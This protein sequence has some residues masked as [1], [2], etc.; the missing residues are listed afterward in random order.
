MVL[1]AATTCLI[2]CSCLSTR[3]YI[4]PSPH[5]LS[6]VAFAGAGVPRDVQPSSIVLSRVAPGATESRRCDC[7]LFLLRQKDACDGDPAC[8][9]NIRFS[10]RPELDSPSDHVLSPVPTLHERARG[11]LLGKDCAWSLSV[12]F[13]PSV[14]RS[15]RQVHRS[16]SGGNGSDP[17]F[18]TVGTARGNIVAR[19]QRPFQV[20]RKGKPRYATRRSVRQSSRR[21]PQPNEGP[22]RRFG[23]S[24]CGR[25]TRLR[26]T[27]KVGGRFCK[28]KRV[29]V[30]RLRFKETTNERRT[31]ITTEVV[32]RRKTNP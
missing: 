2:H 7:L 1:T 5:T 6:G 13:N 10:T 27:E 25:K 19:R 9:A 16:M 21:S 24:A 4:P 11:K 22:C 30:S 32:L 31:G 26:S 20:S 17:C 28:S 3:T 18:A 23:V 29:L 8:D 15:W 14:G 12:W